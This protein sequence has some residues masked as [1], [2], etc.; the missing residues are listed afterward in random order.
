MNIP[1]TQLPKIPEINNEVTY[2][3]EWPEVIAPLL[4]GELLPLVAAA[5]LQ[6]YV[7]PLLPGADVLFLTFVLPPAT[8]QAVC[9]V[10]GPLH[11]YMNTVQ[12]SDR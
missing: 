8:Q 3:P 6:I 11:H 4:L 5:P 7:V 2:L 12:A 1:N 10:T 9:Q